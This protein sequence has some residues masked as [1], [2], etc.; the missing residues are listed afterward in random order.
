MDKRAKSIGIGVVLG[1]TVIG[2]VVYGITML[3]AP[4]TPTTPQQ[5]TT[6]TS[7]ATANEVIYSS[8]GFEPQTLTVPVSTTVTFLNETELPLWVASD[9]H[10]DHTSYPELDTSIE[11][12][13]H[14]PPGNP[15]YSFKFERR[16]TWSY[17]NH[18]QPEHVATITVK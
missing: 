9:P 6:T 3:S 10:P 7:E 16:G 18:S 11:F 15:S 13:D 12:Q 4:S 5:A 14:V 8:A 1:V 17:H 2:V